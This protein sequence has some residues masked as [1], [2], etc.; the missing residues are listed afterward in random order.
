MMSQPRVATCQ[1]CGSGFILTTMYQ[2][3]LARRQ[4]NVVVPVLCPTCFLT[5]GP[6]PKQRGRV[7]WFNATKHYGFIVADTGEEVFF[8]QDQL[9]EEAPRYPQEGQ[10]VRFHLHYPIKGPEAL[11]VEVV[12]D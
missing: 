12:E 10:T 9:L 6:R 7:K 5:K 11:N 8:H 1:Q 3:L 4:V 2:D